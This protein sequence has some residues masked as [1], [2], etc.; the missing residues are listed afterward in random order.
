MTEPL[1]H[2]IAVRFAAEVLELQPRAVSGPKLNIGGK[3]YV[4]STDGGPLAN[5][6]T[7]MLTPQEGG[8]RFIQTPGGNKWR[9]L[10]AYDAENDTVVMYR[11]SDGDEKLYD[12]G[13]HAGL[14]LV[15]LAKKGQLNRVTPQE[16]KA[17]DAFMRKRSHETLE[18]L[19]AIVE[20]NKTTNEHELDDLVRKFFEK[21]VVPHIER[22]IADANRG[23]VPIGF[24]SYDPEGKHVSVERQ[25]AVFIVTQTMKREMAE[26]KVEAWLRQHRFDID[27]VDT[28]SLEWALQEMHEEAYERFLPS[29]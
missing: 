6:L 25:R 23:A 10:W 7:E 27:S 19:K 11:V 9:Y 13:K 17:I 14:Y 29:R 21:H 12:T 1:V 22:G 4:L 3:H 16:F 18:E 26:P 20:K 28:Q 15:R 8:P 5:D 24:K 2:R